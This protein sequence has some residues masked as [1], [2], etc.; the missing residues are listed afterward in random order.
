[1]LEHA[2][3]IRDGGQFRRAA[4][5][6]LAGSHVEMGHHEEREDIHQSVM[7][8]A[9]CLSVIA[10][11]SEHPAGH[12]VPA[13]AGAVRLSMLLWISMLTGVVLAKW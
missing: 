1:M 10:E 12:D 7:E 8:R 3:A 5:D 9:D 13:R 2:K 11:E 6:V 4:H